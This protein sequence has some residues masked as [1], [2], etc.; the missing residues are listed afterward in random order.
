MTQYFTRTILGFP[1]EVRSP[2][3]RVPTPHHAHPGPGGDGQGGGPGQELPR[4]L[5]QVR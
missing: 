3:L 1:P 4:G 5:L 2:M